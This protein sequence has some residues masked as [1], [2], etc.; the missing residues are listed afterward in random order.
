MI[1]GGYQIPKGTAVL[2]SNE[3][4]ARDP[5]HFPDSEKFKPERWLDPQLKQKIHP[6]S[7]RPFGHGCRI[8][9][10]KRYYDNS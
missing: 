6:F 9:I 1:L 5:R 4:L 10:G 3:I 2:F 7:V 8:C